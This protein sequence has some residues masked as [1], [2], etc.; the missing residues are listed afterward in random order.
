MFNTGGFTYK[1]YKYIV[2]KR[3]VTTSEI[4]EEF[5][6]TSLK[7]HHVSSYLKQILKN[8]LI[9]KST[10]RV[11]SKKR[12]CSRSFVYGVSEEEVRKKIEKL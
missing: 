9:V 11:Q 1:I 10:E 5:K 4:A 7:K 2:R 3:A 12:M 8:E 6:N